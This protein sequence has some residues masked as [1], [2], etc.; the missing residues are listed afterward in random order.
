MSIAHV[1]RYWHAGLKDHFYTTNPAEIGTTTT[2]QTGT[3]GYV[4]EGE[5]FTVFTHH[6]HGLVPVYRYYLAASSDHFYTANPNEI[7]ATHVG[8]HG[9]HGYLCE[10]TLGYVSPHAFPGS[11]A[12]HRYYSEAQ[13]DHF[14]TCNDQEIGATHAI[15]SV[16]HHGYKYEGVLGYAYVAQH[17]LTTVHRYWHE[18]SKDHFYT[19][20]GNEIGTTH[21]GHVGNNGYKCEGVSFHLF[22][23]QHPGLIPV[24]R[25][26]KAAASDHFYTAN[27]GEIGATVVGQHGNHGYVC[28][29][30]LG[31]ISP[32]E[33]F[34]SIPVYR[35]WHAGNTDHFY[36]TNSA[37][38]GTTVV[39][40]HGNHG[41]VCEGILGYTPHH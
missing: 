23:H 36:S 31:Y 27:P 35:Y 15:G 37:E 24:Y 18:G 4:S 2:G 10:G 39:G 25:Y 5:A 7:G 20:N 34:G 40:Q 21:T 13:K 38:I 6:H 16:G 12:I 33:F 1:Y 11:V 28:E 32:T 17:N 9:A 29:G 26:W 3:H 41:Y 14:Y 19:A 8:Q 30:I 22:S